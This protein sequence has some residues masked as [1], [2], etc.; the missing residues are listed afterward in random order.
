MQKTKRL[1][2][3]QVKRFITLMHNAELLRENLNLKI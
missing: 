3:K 2:P 1:F